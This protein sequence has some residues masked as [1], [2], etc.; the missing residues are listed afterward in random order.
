MLPGLDGNYY[1]TTVAGG[2]L[3]SGSVFQ[4]TPRRNLHHSHQLHRHL[5]SNPGSS[6]QAALIIGSDNNYYGTTSGGGSS[7]AGVIFKMTARVRRPRS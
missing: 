7:S 3:N 4:V 1:G 5:G 6:P 2:A